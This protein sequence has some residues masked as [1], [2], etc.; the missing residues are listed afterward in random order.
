MI[1]RS[2]TTSSPSVSP[3]PSPR[4]SSSPLATMALLLNT[5]PLMLSPQESDPTR[6]PSRTEEERAGPR[7][8]VPEAGSKEAL[9]RERLLR[10]SQGLE[11][12]SRE[13]E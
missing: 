13:R 2:S 1:V 7:K 6:L 12:A 3:S 8:V 11:T 9:R 5:K 4:L 10:I